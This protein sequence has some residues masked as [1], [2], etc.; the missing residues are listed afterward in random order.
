MHTPQSLYSSWFDTPLGPMLAIATETS[1]Y[2][3]EFKER[4]HL[5]RELD[6]LKT[7]KDIII[8]EKSNP[9]TTTIKDEIKAYF[10]GSLKTFTTPFHLNGTPFQERVWQSLL[11]IP[12]GE[13]RSYQEQASLI[14]K[15]SACRAVANANGKNR[16]AIIV[17]CHRII[18]HNG[19]LGGYGGGIDKKAWLLEHEKSNKSSV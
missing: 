14:D 2:L 16:L 15:A 11:T 3:L 18:N 9:I 19:G 13:T 7:N 6:A 8:K 1:L 12:Y 10:K 17:P 5:D 4:R